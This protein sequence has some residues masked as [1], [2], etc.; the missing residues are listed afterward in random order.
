M[1][2]EIQGIRG[3]KSLETVEIVDGTNLGNLDGLDRLHSLSNLSFSVC[4]ALERLPSLASLSKLIEF[5]SFRCPLLT[6]IEGLGGLKSLQVFEVDGAESLT[7]V[8]GLGNLLCF[9]KL[10]TLRIWNCPR[11]TALTSHGWQP[12]SQIVLESLRKLS[13]RASASLLQS[14]FNQ[15]LHL[16]KFPR[17][18]VLELGEMGGKNAEELLLEGL[19]ALEDL[20]TLMLLGLASIRDYLLCQ[21]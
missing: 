17:L 8:H 20:V 3:L 18:M 19:E 1:L 12:D 10:Q 15:M 7:R 4:D 21:S 13:I 6:E 9:R 16:T 5:H 14:I 11:L 2:R